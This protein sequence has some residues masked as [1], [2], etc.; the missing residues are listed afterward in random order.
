MAYLLPTVCRS[1]FKC[2]FP[3]YLRLIF[4]D[5]GNAAVVDVL[6]PGLRLS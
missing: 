3:C 2:L 4:M 5:S 1:H 6:A